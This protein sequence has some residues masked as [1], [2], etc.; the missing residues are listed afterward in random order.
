MF[1]LSGNRR[2]FEAYGSSKKRLKK[3]LNLIDGWKIRRERRLATGW[4]VIV[5]I[6]WDDTTI[7]LFL[8]VI[9]LILC[10]K[11]LSM[12]IR[13]SYRGVPA[14]QSLTSPLLGN[15]STLFW[16][17]IRNSVLVRRNEFVEYGIPA[18]IGFDRIAVWMPIMLDC[19][20]SCIR[21]SVLWH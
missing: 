17:T 3:R 2:W 16:T 7:A 18:S 19:G 8:T 15:W 21:K 11:K 5:T 4:Y 10:C 9:F 6:F 20:V 14:N 1:K 12:S 13:R